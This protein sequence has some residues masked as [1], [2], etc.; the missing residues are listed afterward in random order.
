VE[1]TADVRPASQQE[2]VPF[3]VDR[4]QDLRI[5][6]DAGEFDAALD[7]LTAL[8]ESDQENGR[9]SSDLQW[10]ETGVLLAQGK[11]LTWEAGGKTAWRQAGSLLLENPAMESRDWRLQFATWLTAASKD[12]VDLAFDELL[13][14]AEAG[15][16]IDERLK[17]WL[18]ARTGD[19]ETALGLLADLDDEQDEIGDLLFRAICHFYAQNVEAAEE[20][21]VALRSRLDRD[22]DMTIHETLCYPLL[23]SFAKKL[24]TRLENK[25]VSAG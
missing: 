22:S 1:D 11:Q 20:N 23:R 9:D 14:N 6:V 12:D 16:A 3:A 15:G 4:L 24:A 13:M 25:Q 21:L 17:A 10:L 2:D 18:L 19:T 8:R 5:Y 7:E